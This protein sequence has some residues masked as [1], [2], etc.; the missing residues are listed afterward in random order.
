MN[1]TIIVARQRAYFQADAEKWREYHR[2]HRAKN[3]DKYREYSNARRARLLNAPAIEKIDRAV[4]VA[5][6]KSTCYM[7]GRILRENEITL[8]HKVPLAR[9]GT[10][11][12]D[13]LAVCCRRCNSRKGVRRVEAMKAILS[14]RT[15]G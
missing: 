1:R 6:D 9:G 11:T 15:P 4:I 2:A 14:D 8:D 5:R 7:C 3:R 13:N 12:S 10:H